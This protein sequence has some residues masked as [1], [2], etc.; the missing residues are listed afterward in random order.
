[1]T[2][3]DD[4][5]R[6]ALAARRS[7]TADER[8]TRSSRIARRFCRSAYFYRSTTLGCYL[9]MRDEV[10]TADV[11]DRAWRADKRVFVPVMRSGRRLDFVEIRPDTRLSRNRLGIWEPRGGRSIRPRDL[12]VCIVPTVAFD[13]DGNRIGMG[14]GYYDRAFEFRNRPGAWR[15]PRLVGFAFECQRIASIVPNHWD[16]ALDVVMSDRV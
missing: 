1:M 6:D 16:V 15:R 7:L 3:I 12:D 11:I 2:V 10:E 14:G 8:S 13:A 9:P 4:D 5:R